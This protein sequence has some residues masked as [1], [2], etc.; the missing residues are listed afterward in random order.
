MSGANG[1]A[2][3]VDG[4][5]AVMG[6][7]ALAWVTWQLGGFLPGTMVVGLP[8]MFAVAG[9]VALRWWVVAPTGAPVGWWY[10]LPLLGWVTGHM[11]GLAEL[12]SRGW[13]QGWHLW[14]GLAA[15]W[16]GLHLARDPRLWRLTLAGVGGVALG[17]GGAAIY[18]QVGDP[19]WLPLG[20]EQ[21][22]HYLGRSAGTF[23][24]PNN[25]AAWMAIVLAVAAGWALR[26]DAGANWRQRGFAA[27]VAVVALG[28]IVMS[29]SRGVTLALLGATAVAWLIHGRWSGGRR[30]AL[31]LGLGVVLALV[32]WVGYQHNAQVQ[33]RI[34]SLVEH[35]GER[36]RPLLWG[37]AIDLWQE[38]PLVGY[39]G[40]S[41][42]DLME[43]HRPE[44]LWE[45]ANY[46]HNEYLNGLS[47]YGAIGGLLALAAV[48]LILRRRWR[49]APDQP[50]IG[51]ALATLM[52]AILI[53]FHWQAPAV[54]WLA[55]MLLG[56]W[57]APGVGAGRADSVEFKPVARRGLG[58]AVMLGFCVLP[59][60]Q[61][62]PRFQAE[63]V[64][65]RAR[66]QVD[67][68]A[69]DPRPE[70]IRAVATSA[71]RTLERAVNLDPDNDE[72]W[73]D[74]AYAL[75]LQSFGEPESARSAGR[76]AERAARRALAASPMVA[77]NWVR[78]GVALDQQGRW[79]EAGPAFGRAVNLAPRQP[80]VWYYQ[81][82]HLSLKPATREL[83]KAALA[84]CLR[85]D[86]W[87]DEAKLLKADLERTP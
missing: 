56:A 31:G 18:Q 43:R 83:A 78:L 63:E 67:D 59:L 79:A 20:R 27:T 41:F 54:G 10:P 55:A 35:R 52:L 32:G 17:V 25:M 22:A 14:S 84:T 69:G 75:S 87:Y 44:G 2:R 26:R 65:W 70:T 86:P 47:D 45:S 38:R 24:N 28:G 11:L 15:Y 58:M 73:R 36:T 6:V 64:R 19:G 4:T 77:E 81:A 82:F 39:G 48:G 12:P 42:G 60:I 62:V 50:G 34:D 49:I 74:L 3:W 8:G 5:I 40:G 53:D 76:E 37:V 9:L 46:A 16:L 23:G 21:A 61:A 66:E 80:V 71:V 29:Y 51:L 85:L 30:V 1:I 7:A 72:A 13:L 57:M 33:Q 68:L